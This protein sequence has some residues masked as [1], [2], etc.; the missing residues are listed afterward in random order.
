MGVLIT[1]K[2]YHSKCFASRE[3]RSIATHRRHLDIRFEFWPWSYLFG[4]CSGRGLLAARCWCARTTSGACRATPWSLDFSWSRGY[5]PSIWRTVRNASKLPV[6]THKYYTYSI[7]IYLH[8]ISSPLWRREEWGG[9]CCKKLPNAHQQ[10]QWF[11]GR[12][13]LYTCVHDRL[14]NNETAYFRFL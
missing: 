4:T 6:S 13:R 1:L 7:V 12:L 9:V 10:V 2:M 3:T 8:V 5:S 11:S 14:K